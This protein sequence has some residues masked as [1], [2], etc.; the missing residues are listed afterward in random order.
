MPKPDMKLWLADTRGIYIPRD[1]ANSFADRA[2][3]VEGVPDTEWTV[4]EAGPDHEWY[5]ESWQVVCD[6][7]IVTD[8]NGVKYSV[9][10]DGDCWLIPHGME[11]NERTG[12]FEWPEEETEED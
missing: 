6:N 8:E 4:L 3:S 7:A 10:Q 9:W 12:C 5:W 1:F 11:L 2:K